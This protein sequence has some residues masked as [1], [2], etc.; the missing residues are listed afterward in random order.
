M[1]HNSKHCCILSVSACIL[2][3]YLLKLAAG[4]TSVYLYLTRRN[5][6]VYLPF[7]IRVSVVHLHVMVLLNVYDQVTKICFDCISV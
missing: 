2:I 6:T 7:L 1:M 3:C 4:K 5:K